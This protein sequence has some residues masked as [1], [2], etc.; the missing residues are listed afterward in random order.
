MSFFTKFQYSRPSKTIAW[1]YEIAP[2]DKK[3]YLE[4]NY[5]VTRLWLSQKRDGAGTLTLTIIN[6]WESRSAFDQWVH[7]SE[8]LE[9]HRAR[10]TYNNENGIVVLAEEYYSS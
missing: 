6:E 4:T 7:D 8:L 9:W 10:D 3:S 5:A 2:R 1:Y